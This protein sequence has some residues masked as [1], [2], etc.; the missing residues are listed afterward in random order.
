MLSRFSVPS[1]PEAGDARGI[2]DNI[3]SSIAV[4]RPYDEGSAIR[5]WN[6]L[7]SLRPLCLAT[8]IVFVVGS[9]ETHCVLS[10]RLR[11]RDALLRPSDA[12]MQ[13]PR[14]CQIVAVT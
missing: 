5:R 6:R 11:V 14:F 13:R 3:P 2:A 7:E 8:E 9:N 12:A 4:S 10:E 1:L